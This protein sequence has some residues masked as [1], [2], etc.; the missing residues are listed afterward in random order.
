MAET[1]L[2]QG[3]ILTFGYH[4]SYAST[5][6]LGIPGTPKGSCAVGRAAS[7]L[8]PGTFV[9]DSALLSPQSATL[10][11]PYGT[12]MATSLSVVTVSPELG[13]GGKNSLL[14]RQIH[15]EEG[16]PRP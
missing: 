1:S 4:Q 6:C 8:R 10:E 3:G 7:C 11:Q 5:Y 16:G 14:T 15:S 9:S 12:K 2:W 13:A